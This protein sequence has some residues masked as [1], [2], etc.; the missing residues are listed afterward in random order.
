MKS[1]R[2]TSR[3]ITIATLLCFAAPQADQN[4][5]G[6]TTKPAQTSG[7]KKPK[8]AK[9]EKK[10]KTKKTGNQAGQASTHK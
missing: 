4:P 1:F 2:Q 3:G 7:S 6:G 8:K 9:K 10:P 5:P